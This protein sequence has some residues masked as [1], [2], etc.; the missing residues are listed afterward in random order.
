MEFV[1]F[2]GGPK[3]SPA[4][5][6]EVAAVDREERH[7]LLNRNWRFDGHSEIGEWPRRPRGAGLG[8]FKLE[9]QQQLG[10]PDLRG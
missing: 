3:T 4:L 10:P 1:F 8:W 2:W 6:P 9:K 7:G 5:W